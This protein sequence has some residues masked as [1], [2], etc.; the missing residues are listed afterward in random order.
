MNVESLTSVPDGWE[1]PPPELLAQAKD[2][3]MEALQSGGSHP[4][5]DRLARFYDTT[6]DYAG[7]SFAQLQ[8]IDP[9]DFTPSDVLATTLMSVHIGA[10]ATR[11][12]LQDGAARDVLLRKL[13]DIPDA[14][15][16]C[17]GIPEL[18][19]MAELYEEIKRVLSADTVKNPNAWV[20]ASK[21]CARKRPKLFPARDR[22]ACDHLGLSGFKNY[23][24]DWQVFRNLMEDQ[25]VIAAI[26]E[27]AKATEATGVGRQLQLDH[28]RL[29]LLDAAIWT[30]A[31]SSG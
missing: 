13:R 31:K 29:R 16:G 27:M 12:I 10:S 23:Q 24:V 14:E 30:Y 21:L 19:A 3:T 4:A 22:K 6:G 7:A 18:M 25:E 1:H 26:D 20:T 9:L 11:R 17:A 2:K 28:S 5:P 8:P 15:L